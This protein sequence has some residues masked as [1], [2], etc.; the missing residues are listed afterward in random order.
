M[1]P[2]TLSTWALLIARTLHARAIDAEPLFRAAGMSYE[3]LR[4]VDARYPVGAMQRLWTLATHA[5]GDPCVG[6]A[7]GRSWHPTTFHALGYAA[8]ASAS[9]KDALACVVRYS[10][11]VS[12]AARLELFE[13]NDEIVMS[14]SPA[15]DAGEGH[16]AAVLAALAAIVVLCRVAH[17]DALP[18]ARL[19]LVQHPRRCRQALAEFFACR[20]VLGADGNC[21]A[22]RR[23]H[24]E[25]RLPTANLAL[26]R[27]NERVLARQLARVDDVR[28]RER[29]AAE[30][31]RRLPAG[32]PAQAAIARAL[33]L[34][35]RSLQRKL[36]AEGCTF[37]ALVDAIRARLARDYANDPTLASAEIAYL[38][39]FADPGSF[40]RA[41]RR[42]NGAG[43]R[44]V[45][46]A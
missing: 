29:A 3:R 15:R 36:A 7:V 4:D 43:P 38:L 25:A 14:L 19:T 11:V 35:P 12:S 2:S 42:W 45:Q 39:G 37:R 33:N 30:V 1:G 28:V 32:R 10:G 41:R 5:S 6:L 8:L 26:A 13:R 34:S 44:S 40:L 16:E 21:I 17:A 24:A 9:L 27:L 18:L 46:R 31:V 22:Y 23:K 20:I